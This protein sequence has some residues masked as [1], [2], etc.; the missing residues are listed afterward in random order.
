MLGLGDLLVIGTRCSSARPG[1]RGGRGG[2][3]LSQ[4]PK[5]R[6]SAASKAA[7]RDPAV[8]KA[9]RPHSPRRRLVISARG[10]LG[11]LVPAPR[12]WN[13]SST[14][15]FPAWP[16]VAWRMALAQALQATLVEPPGMRG[17]EISAFL[18]HAQARSSRYGVPASSMVG[19]IPGSCTAR[20]QMQVPR[21]RWPILIDLHRGASARRDRPAASPASS[22]SRGAAP[23]QQRSPRPG[24]GRERAVP[25]L[26]T[27]I[28]RTGRNHARQPRQALSR[29]NAAAHRP[30]DDIAASVTAAS[31]T[32]VAHGEDGGPPA[33][34][35]R[36]AREEE[37]V[38][39]GPGTRCLPARSRAVSSA[40]REGAGRQATREGGA[41][42]P[43]RCPPPA[44][45]CRFALIALPSTPPMDLGER[46]EQRPSTRSSTRAYPRQPA[47]IV[48]APRALRSFTGSGFARRWLW[49]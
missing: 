3:L 43:C 8:E 41:R 46:L 48:V 16:Q 35:V 1:A 44:S 12:G 24:A 7:L 28:W 33:P 21:W 23:A 34:H 47:A 10:I 37:A 14:F 11:G 39:P 25:L 38:M 4:R 20:D 49:R 19:R 40:W 27:G 30:R 13:S 6:S 18:A 36:A 5:A 42:R 29:R 2:R 31:W 26:G 32:V 15:G 22:A 9:A 17:G 45:A